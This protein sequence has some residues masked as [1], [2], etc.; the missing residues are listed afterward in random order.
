MRTSQMSEDIQHLCRT[1]LLHDGAGMTDGQLLECF[2]TQREDATFAALVRRHGPMVWGVCRRVLGSHHDAED[3]FQATFLVLVRKAASV[4]PRD[5]LANWLY[6]VAH[7][8]AL[9]A[10]ATAAR[11]RTHER[12]VAEMPEPAVE[13]QDLC[14]DV[15]SVLDQ[16]L[17]RLP[18][19][20]RAAIVLC[21]LEG[22][23]R[24]EAAHLLGAPEGTLSARLTR[25]RAMLAKRLTRRGVGVA[26]AALGVMLSQK[27]ATAG[28]PTSVVSSTIK[29]ASHFAAG[30]RA[31]TS[32]ISAKAAILTEGVL[33]SMLLT[34]LKAAAA[35]LMVVG[36]SVLGLAMLSTRD[37]GA[38]AQTGPPMVAQL[39]DPEHAGKG[40]KAPEGKKMDFDF[41]QNIPLSERKIELFPAATVTRTEKKGLV[42]S[43]KITNSSS[44]DIKTM[45][46]YEWHG[47]LWPPTSLYAIAT[48]EKGKKVRAFMPVYRAGRD[49]I[50]PPSVTIGPGK[51]IDV[52]LRMDW[53]GTGSVI[54]I[55]LIQ[56]PGK[57]TVRFALVFEVAGKQQ[58]VSTTANVVELLPK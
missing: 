24:R 26:G 48:P 51:S 29:A 57:Y 30:H 6:G 5:M 38:V 4:V 23:T 19:R 54:G 56:A 47:G 25:G 2:V 39:G 12:Q 37:T 41:H 15:Q 22:K 21:D 45:M 35:V 40:K 10:R 8:T 27:V 58:Y 34:K 42:L 52:E 28:V 36:L 17:S 18:D 9:N 11:R 46:A 13:E 53:D 3:A 20:Y 1:F 44:D 16:E 31:A 50:A 7:Q 14:R 49:Q 43:L 32:V 55:P 33:K